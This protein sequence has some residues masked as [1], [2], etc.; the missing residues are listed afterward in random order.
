MD[1]IL[2][3]VFT[4][5]PNKQYLGIV[6]PTTPATTGPDKYKITNHILSTRSNDN[7]PFI[8]PYSYKT[9]ITKIIQVRGIWPFKITKANNIRQTRLRIE[10]APNINL[11]ITRTKLLKNVKYLEL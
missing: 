3:A 11:S 6:F 9:N 2:E 10:K 8:F 7:K 1:S 5:S 4:V